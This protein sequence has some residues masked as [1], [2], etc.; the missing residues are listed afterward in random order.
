MTRVA[1]AATP[2]AYA[3]KLQWRDGFL[4]TAQCA[5]VLE[6]LE[7][8]FWEPS[9]VSYFQ[10][11]R[12]PRNGF[13]RRRVSETAQQ[14]WFSKPIERLLARVDARLERVLPHFTSRREPWQAT[15][16]GRGGKFDYHL[17]SG[18]FRHEP[19]GERAHTVMIYLDRPRSGGSTHFCELELDIQPQP[20][21]LVL[22]R[23]VAR[24][25]AHSLDREMLHS[26]R[27]VR[28]GHKTVLV[29]WVRQRAHEKG[30]PR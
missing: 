1:K 22:W 10:R 19:A 30:K 20:G 27:P 5:L 23:N 3:D 26:S 28:A 29:T 21:R 4:T 16:Y 15:R 2:P 17:D 6:E 13:S 12:G 24:D 8:A 18:H 25:R 11:G 7:F 14:R 9:G